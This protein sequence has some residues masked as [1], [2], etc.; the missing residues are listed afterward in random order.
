MPKKGK[1]V[2]TEK[3]NP[4]A[5]RVVQLNPKS[6][7]TGWPYFGSRYTEKKR[8]GL[9]RVTRGNARG[10]CPIVFTGCEKGVR[11]DRRDV[12]KTMG[13]VVGSPRLEKLK[14]NDLVH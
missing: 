1:K 3:D 8:Q 13:F 10:K 11:Q 14:N 7:G 6:N 4:W 5:T 2:A 9:T 12:Q